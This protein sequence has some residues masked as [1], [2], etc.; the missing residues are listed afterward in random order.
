MAKSPAKKI[1]R[2]PA[3]TRARLLEAAEAA[4]NGPGYFDTDT[5]RIARAAGFAPQTFY[6]HFTDKTEI[7]LAVYDNWWRS[8]R[9]AILQSQA[10]GETLE[11]IATIVIAF[12]TRW[13]VFRRALRHLSIVDDRVRAAR[14]AARLAQ[15]ASLPKRKGLDESARAAA[16]LKLERI[17]DAVA[18]GEFSDMGFSRMA[19]MRAVVECL[20]VL[21]P[22]R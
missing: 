2:N 12:H 4:F 18:E 14:A 11:D 6:R 5:N 15:L 10:K 1:S 13:R 8:E 17:S 7:F 20:K 16:L 21:T 22:R 3:D 9:A 19:A